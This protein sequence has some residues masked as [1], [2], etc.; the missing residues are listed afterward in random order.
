LQLSYDEP[1][2]KHGILALN[3][4]HENLESGTP[5]TAALFQY[6]RVV[7]HSNRL[8]TAH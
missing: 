7:C 3:T 4:M 6:I 8:L 1:A 2:I 5:G